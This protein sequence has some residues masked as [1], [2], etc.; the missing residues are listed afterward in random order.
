MKVI[1]LAGGYATRLH[2]L[3]LNQAKPLL[4]V[5]GKPMVEHIINK[6][7]NFSQINKIFI[8]T[9]QKFHQDFENWNSTFKS[10][11]T[12][13]IINDGTTSNEDRLGAIGDIQFVINQENINDD[14]MIIAGDN[15]FEDNLLSFI[16]HFNEK[17]SSILVNDVGCFEKAKKFGIVETN[18]NN[19][20]ISFL[21]KPEK[22]PSTLA[23]TCIYAIKKEHL[24]HIQATINSGLSDR[25]GDFIK[26]LS[27]NEHVSAIT[28]QGK[29][30]DIGSLDS[31][32]EANEVY[33]YE[34]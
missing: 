14:L 17:G 23:A 20:I 15:L 26:H 34:N 19:K 31:L 33:S 7:N 25:P 8:V 22:P 32:N 27:Q 6:F 16:N 1:I 12:I 18:E 2:P 11:K 30:F 24:P 28:L 10:N 21:E 4:K 3:T 9:N 13:K 5:A 29:W